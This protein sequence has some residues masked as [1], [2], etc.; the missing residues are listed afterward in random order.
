[1]MDINPTQLLSK[2]ELTYVYVLKISIFLLFFFLFIIF[3]KADLNNSENVKRNIETIL[4]NETSVSNSYSMSKSLVDLETIGIF[5]CAKLIEISN[6]NRIYYDSIGNQNCMNFISLLK[7]K[8]KLILTGLNGISYELEYYASTNL[9]FRLFEL[10][11]YIILTTSYLFLPNIFIQII[12]NNSMKIKA[13][14]IEKKNLLDLSQQISHD[15]ASPLSAIQLVVGLLKNIDPE[16]KEVLLKSVKRTQKIFDE[17]KQSNSIISTVNISLCLSEI[18]N[19]KKIQWKDTCEIVIED[20][21]LQNPLVIAEETKLKRIISNIL[22]NSCEAFDKKSKNKILISIVNHNDKTMLNISDNGK[23]IP[24]H[25]L[26][27]IGIKGFSY[28][29]EN[30]NTAGS[31][32]GLFQAIETLKSWGGD[33][34]I[35]SIQNQGTLISIEFKIS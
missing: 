25:I 5:N 10:L 19:E 1:M 17:L 21:F 34:K 20:K 32:L 26:E 6:K 15:V 13:L 33:I 11:V 8:E 14:E 3:R 24:A 23:G 18:I 12:T 22:N 9:F 27:K 4:R 30:Y 35:S 29:K 16:I 28:G 7:R 31:G 2:P